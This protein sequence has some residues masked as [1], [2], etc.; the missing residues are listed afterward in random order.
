MGDQVMLTQES[1]P[2]N[3]QS[4]KKEADEELIKRLSN[5]LIHPS[6]SDL[7]PEEQSHNKIIIRSPQ[8]DIQ[9]EKIMRGQLGESQN[10]A[11]ASPIQGLRPRRNIQ[12]PARHH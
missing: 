5:A 7:N 10:I 8:K 4:Q 9:R 6:S 3:D 12:K 1:V 2:L 11:L